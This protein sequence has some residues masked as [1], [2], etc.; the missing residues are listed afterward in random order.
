MKGFSHDD[1]W[2]V[3]ATY[4]P[5]VT[6]CRIYYFK[7]SS[8]ASNENL[9]KSMKKEGVG[10]EKALQIRAA[11]FPSR[12]TPPPPPDFAKNIRRVTRRKADVKSKPD[13]KTRT[14]TVEKTPLVEKTT[15][16]RERSS[17][18]RLFHRPPSRRPPSSRTPPLIENRA[19]VRGFSHTGGCF[20]A[21]TSRSNKILSH[22]NLSGQTDPSL[23]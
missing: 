11:L 1:G 13:E 3:T 15:P 19:L 4:Y 10:S 7:H 14:K 22:T 5:Q 23:K 6:T 16:H 21:R 8:F 12:Y 17:C 20:S 2:S 9:T 18:E